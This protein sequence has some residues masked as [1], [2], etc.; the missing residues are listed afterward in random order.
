MVM[1]IITISGV[2]GSGKTTQLLL[3]KEYLEKKGFSVVL[4]HS[5]SFSL[6]NNLLKKKKEKLA[7]RVKEKS[8]VSQ[9]QV[10]IFEE[11]PAKAITRSGWLGILAR[12]LVL[13]IDLYRFRRLLVKLS[14]EGTDYLLS[15]RYFYDQIVN[16]LYLSFQER[17]LHNLTSP[18]KKKVPVKL[19]LL[20][21]LADRLIVKPDRSFFIEVKPEVVLKRD[22]ELEQDK[23]YL[24][25]KNS[26]YRKFVPHWQIRVLNGQN[27]I[28]NIQEKI[29]N[30][31][32]V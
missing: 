7:R 6:V 11:E 13:L 2:D 28:E 4:F 14:R 10:S 29:R 5:V 23:N 1:K 25:I 16:I 20:L 30:I 26:L 27:S 17:I 12:K 9:E 8:K 32:G 19:S 15:D 21:R 18:R 31:I 3:L 22:K 24:L